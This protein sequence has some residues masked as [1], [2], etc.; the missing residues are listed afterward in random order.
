MRLL[1][2]P[3]FAVLVCAV[4]MVVF[5]VH[6]PV[7]ELLPRPFN[8]IGLV[9]LAA[10]IAVAKWHAGLFRRIGTNIN[11]FGEPGTL[12]REGLF[13]HTRNPMYLGMLLA[14]LGL[15]WALGSLSPWVGPLAF[16]ILASRWYVPAEESAMAA[17]FGAAYA[18]YRR[19]V[20]RWL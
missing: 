11:T 6:W 13:R 18:Q 20:R 10:G 5:H 3:P 4:L 9:P 8:W 14:L 12:T 19:D 16:F 2:L 17:K 15:A 7:M 1:L